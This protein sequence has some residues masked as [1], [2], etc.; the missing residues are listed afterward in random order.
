M[1]FKKPIAY[2]TVGLPGSGK[3]T[4]AKKFIMNSVGNVVTRTNNDEIR[5]LIYDKQQNHTWTRTVEDKVRRL[6]EEAIRAAYAGNNSIIIDN[7]HMNPKTLASTE[8]FCKNFGFEVEI[9]DFRHVHIDECIRRDALRSVGEKV[10][11]DMA[12]LQI[13]ID[14]GMPSYVFSKDTPTCLIVDIDGT[15]AKMGDRSPYDESKVD[16]DSVRQHVLQTVQSIMTCNPL[17]EL[18]IFSG[19][20]EYCKD[21]TN[22]WLNTK[23]GMFEKTQTL[24]D[25]DHR[26][27]YSLH[28]RPED[29]RRRDS[30]IK[31]DMYAEFI[32]DKYNIFAVFD[33]RPQVIRECW[34]VLKLPVFNCGLLDV[35]F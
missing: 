21:A 30:L 11:R 23:C 9:V 14:K 2:I 13:Q 34:N 31:M 25:D 33:D 22:E 5:N 27:I 28:M 6:R 24:V 15:L 3:S 20:S 12:K 18:F 4:W 26:F 7:T 8:K 17:F 1:M 16:I 29:D 10:I 32:K 19:R 35:E